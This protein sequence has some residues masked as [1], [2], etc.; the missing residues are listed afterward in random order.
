MHPPH[1]EEE[2]IAGRKCRRGE[3]SLSRRGR[4]RRGY[5][6]CVCCDWVERQRAGAGVAD[7]QPTTTDA[8]TVVSVRLKVSTGACE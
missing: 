4:Y 3:P 1:V 2:Q 5:G 6:A 7:F 8:V